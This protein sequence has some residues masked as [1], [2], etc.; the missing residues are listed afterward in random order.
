MVKLLVFIRCLDI[1][2]KEHHF[3]GTD[4][5]T[6]FQFLIHFVTQADK[7][8]TS[9]VQTYLALQTYITQTA[10]SQFMYMQ[11]GICARGI[12]Y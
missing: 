2:M 10:K 7:R 4:P 6:V 1:P 8:N 5:I 3:D 12:T 11:I 9:K